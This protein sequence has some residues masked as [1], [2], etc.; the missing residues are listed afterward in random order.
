MLTPSHESLVSY[1]VLVAANIVL[2]TAS[3]WKM[4]S[5]GIDVAVLKH[6]RLMPV[7]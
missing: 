3:I 1:S 4:A 7:L 6:E 5:A 2:I